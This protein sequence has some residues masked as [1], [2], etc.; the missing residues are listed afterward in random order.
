MFSA[1]ASSFWTL[2]PTKQVTFRFSRSHILLMRIL[3]NVQTDGFAT[4][5]PRGR[6]WRHQWTHGNKDLP[7]LVILEMQIGTPLWDTPARPWGWPLWLAPTWGSYKL[8]QKC[9]GCGMGVGRCEVR[10]RHSILYVML[11]FENENNSYCLYIGKENSIKS[12]LMV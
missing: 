1:I 12:Q 8:H 6:H 7:S 4:C 3:A 2:H 11:Y 10:K 9:S 5:E